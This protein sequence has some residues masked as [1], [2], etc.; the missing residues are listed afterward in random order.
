VRE[1]ERIVPLPKGEGERIVPLPEGQEVG[2]V[3]ELS[4]MFG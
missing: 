1:K 2:E 3:A 4:D